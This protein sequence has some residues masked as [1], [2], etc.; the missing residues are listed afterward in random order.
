MGPAGQST[1]DVLGQFTATISYKDVST[2]EV[3]Y[4]VDRQEHALLSNGACERLKSLT[5][6]VDS[7]NEYRAKYSELFEV[8]G[9]LRDYPARPS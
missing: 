4:V 3:L 6:H 8:L 1:L 5:F 7:V 9:E 2:E